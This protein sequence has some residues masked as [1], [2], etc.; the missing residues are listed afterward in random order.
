M[1]D[2]I[3]RIVELI[4]RSAGDISFG[5]AEIPAI[6]YHKQTIL[7]LANQILAL[8]KEGIG[9]GLLTK[10]ERDGVYDNLPSRATCGEERIAYCQAQLDKI[11]KALEV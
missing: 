2:K 8:I 5:Y 11:L 1:R 7:P 10:E 4:Q 3:A 9:K 6:I